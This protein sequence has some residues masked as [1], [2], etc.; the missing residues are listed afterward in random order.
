MWRDGLD[1][2]ETSRTDLG[3]RETSRVS[4]IGFNSNLRLAAGRYPRGRV[5]GSVP[6]ARLVE[7]SSRAP[8]LFP[9]TK[10]AASGRPFPFS[11]IRGASGNR[12]SAHS[13]ASSGRSGLVPAFPD[14]VPAFPVPPDGSD[15]SFLASAVRLDPAC[16]V[17]AHH[18]CRNYRLPPKAPFMHSRRERPEW[19]RRANWVPAGFMP[20]ENTSP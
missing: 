10:R 18:S 9:Q 8:R 3:S 4:F 5:R 12:P 7:P 1:M 19:P 6:S 11:P 15:R 17:P 13:Q 16:S 14:P 2:C 20:V